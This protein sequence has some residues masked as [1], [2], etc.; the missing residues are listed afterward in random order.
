MMVVVSQRRWMSSGS[1]SGE[2]GKSGGSALS[3]TAAA[4]PP[5]RW[6]PSWMWLQLRETATHY[7]HGSKLLYMDTRIAAK[8][9]KRMING[10]TLSRREH[11]LL[12]RVF[13]D[14]ARLVPL[15][16]FV[17]VPMMEFALPFAI[18]IFPNLLPSTFEEKHH[19]EEQRKKLLKVRMEMAQVMQHTM[20]ERAAQVTKEE[21]AKERAREES[22]R[23][24]SDMT[25]VDNLRHIAGA[26]PDGRLN[27]DVKEF[28]MRMK[29]GGRAAS[30]D[31]LL[32]MM[33]GFKDNVTLDHLYRDQLVAMAQFLNMNH[34]A[35]TGLLRF[36]VRQRLKRLR[37]E[38]KD[39]MWEGV[40]GLSEA[41]LQLDL[42]NRGIP[43]SK[44]SRDEMR[45][46]LK[47]WL[48]LS[49]VKEIPYSLLILTNMLHFAGTRHEQRETARLGQTADE[50]PM[51]PLAAASAAMSSLPSEMASKSTLCE[52]VTNDDK[53]EALQREEALVEEERQVREEAAVGKLEDK[54]FDDDEE[55][56]VPV[57]TAAVAKAPA[58]GEALS[59]GG[60]GVP[61][62]A[63]AEAEEKARM[64]REQIAD[65]AEAIDTM[66]DSPIGREKEE[67]EELEAE[68]VADR[69]MVEE[70]KGKSKQVAMLDSRVASM[71]D[72]IKAEMEDS[73]LS[74]G[75]AFHKLDLDGDGL[76]SYNELMGAIDELHDS[77]R[78]DAKAFQE[79]LVK[80]DVDA[81]GQISVADVR[82]LMKDMREMADADDDE[83][84]AFEARLSRAKEAAR[85]KEAAASS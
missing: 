65:L 74:I 81:D 17:L 48:S 43:T 25:L 85:K 32:S 36:Q 57:A 44:L 75:E 9:L 46:A 54:N 3:K 16:F 77:K 58:G 10:R 39:I 50:E 49:Q 73:E 55:E 70:A 27:S 7:W 35:P 83:A 66:I 28:M 23:G 51:I 41:E 53:I 47:Q 18:R 84:D 40:E 5:A 63:E 52:D 68:R 12:V 33:R 24:G 26:A 45:E 79:L 14:I 34:F 15:S 31:E 67:M 38:D 72:K 19:K 62:A 60:T 69:E 4:P 21:R 22:E 30:P 6:T 13:A 78:P 20:N 8:L 80:L 82:K 11:N 71:L 59:G 1:K 37:S 64:T 56:V 76:L 2:S 42:R 29:E 61:E